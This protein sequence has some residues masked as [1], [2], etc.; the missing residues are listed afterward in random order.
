[1][2]RLFFCVYLALVLI[3]IPSKSQVYQ[4]P[5]LL[6]KISGKE[7]A[8][9][10]YLFGTMHTIEKSQFFL[11]SLTREAFN[12][13]KILATENETILQYFPE[14]AL[15]DFRD[16]YWLSNRQTLAQVMEES[17]YNI[18]VAQMKKWH[19]YKKE[20]LRLKP[21]YVAELLLS[22]QINTHQSNLTGYE[23]VFYR[24]ALARKR[25]QRPMGIVGLE[26]YKST[27]AY[28]DSI[29]IE[30]QVSDLMT[31][32]RNDFRSEK[33]IDAMYLQ[34]DIVGLWQYVQMAP[35]QYRVL[36]EIR[37]HSWLDKIERLVH[38]QPTFI[39]VGAAHLAGPDGLIQ[40]LTDRGYELAPVT[41]HPVETNQR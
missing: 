23:I 37:N 31:Y 18:L 34:Q 32:I 4:Q 26:P 15:R 6:W 27:M 25:T 17:Q 7:L 21:K 40:L 20:N 30:Q 41:L 38:S 33:Q 22:K 2:L 10:S 1:M 36:V 8:Q 11:P 5:Y 16:S 24:W 3:P 19:V 39:A 9:P 28:L 12:L 29:S 13:C 14:E 35:E